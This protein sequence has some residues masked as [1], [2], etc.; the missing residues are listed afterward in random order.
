MLV[1]PFEWV[2][3]ARRVQSWNGNPVLY[4]TLNLCWKKR[5]NNVITFHLDAIECNTLSS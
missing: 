1:S 3:P 5:N 2:L 4:F